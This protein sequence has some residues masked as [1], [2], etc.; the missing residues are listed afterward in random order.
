MSRESESGRSVSGV[1]KI[2]EKE[3]SESWGSESGEEESG[4]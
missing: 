2:N 3:K 1:N 4:E